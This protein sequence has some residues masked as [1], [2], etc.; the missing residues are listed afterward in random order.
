MSDWKK[1]LA[2]VAPILA[3]A[4][5]GPFAGS[6]VNVIGKALLGRD[7]SFTTEMIS[8]AVISATPEQL[9]ALNNADNDFKAKMKGLNVE[10]RKSARGFA[11]NT[12]ILPQV[13]LSVIYTIGYFGLIYN[14][15]TGEI[16]I[17]EDIIMMVMPLI[18]IMTGAQ[19]QILNFWFGSSSGSK[20]KTQKLRAQ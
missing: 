7:G 1:T 10:D 14:L 12:T 13:V 8:Q 4:L 3:T 6:A 5:G 9:Q 17:P 2:A 18:G 11:I 16:V 15:M 19:T 20:E